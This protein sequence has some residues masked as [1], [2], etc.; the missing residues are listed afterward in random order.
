M[1][2]AIMRRSVVLPQPRGSEKEEELARLDGQADA[3]HGTGRGR[4][5]AEDLDQ[6]LDDDPGAHGLT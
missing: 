6:I 4:P 3:V 1:N 2:P 5:A